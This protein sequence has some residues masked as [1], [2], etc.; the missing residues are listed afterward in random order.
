MDVKLVY[1]KNLTF[2][3]KKYLL[4]KERYIVLRGGTRSGKTYSALQFIFLNALIGRFKLCSIVSINHPHLRRGAQ[5]DFDN[6]ITQAEGW[7]YITRNKSSNTYVFF[8]GSEVEFFA[9][10]D[11]SKAR[12]GQRDWLFVNEVNLIS[13]ELFSELDARTKELVILDF[14][15]VSK[16]WLNDLFISMNIELSKIE[17][18][19]TYLD[20]PFLDKT[21]KLAIE[22][23]KNKEE[24]FKVYGLGEWGETKGQA[25]YSWEII[26]KLPKFHDNLFDVIGV[27]FGF[28]SSP[29]A[30]IGI[31]VDGK[32]VYVKEIFYGNSSLSQLVDI[33]QKFKAR[34]IV[35]DSANIDQINLLRKNNI[36]IYPGKKMSL[37]ASYTLLNSLNVYIDKNSKNLISEAQSLTWA[38]KQNALTKGNDHA[39]DALRYCIHE[40]F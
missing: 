4:D 13:E 12:G 33:L 16:F 24:W 23:R 32:N 29:T 39:I 9:V 35:G 14:N 37:L 17:C 21:Q 28:G 20:N 7:K 38:D 8:N 10:D 18:V 6:I 36:N 30:V 2:L 3:L 31:V 26:D 34:K 27:D 22:S 11:P 40:V 5:R 19:S 1:N 25:F 15:P